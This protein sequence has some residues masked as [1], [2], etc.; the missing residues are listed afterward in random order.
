MSLQQIKNFLL[1]PIHYYIIKYIIIFNY[2]FNF[3]IKRAISII[4]IT[5][6]PKMGA[7]LILIYF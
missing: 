5:F 6:N 4:I 7:F 1:I 2:D 3:K